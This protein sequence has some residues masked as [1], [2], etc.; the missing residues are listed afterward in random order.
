MSVPNEQSEATFALQ[1]EDHTMGNA[2]RYM[3]NKNPHVS[4]AVRLRSFL[5]TCVRDTTCH[6]RGC[7]SCA[8]DACVLRRRGTL[9][10]TPQTTSCTYACRRPVMPQRHKH[11]GTR[12]QVRTA[13]VARR[14][15]LRTGIF[16]TA[17]LSARTAL[18]RA[19]ATHL[20]AT[21]A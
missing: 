7:V 10:R 18:T 14:F 9:C 17:V 13:T 21:E 2:L 8:D 4:F 15:V 1:G 11:L 20:H 19:T 16:H 3:L 6:S 12:S 5:L